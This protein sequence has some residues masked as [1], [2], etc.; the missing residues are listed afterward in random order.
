MENNKIKKS[1][2]KFV[3]ILGIIISIIMFA[4]GTATQKG[5]KV[6]DIYA[7][8]LGVG[9]IIIIVGCCMKS[10]KKLDEMSGINKTISIEKS[11]SSVKLNTINYLCCYKTISIINYRINTIF[12]I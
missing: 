2:K 10:Q 3:I 1:K 8:G 4:I 12:T 5:D 6:D 7:T 11:N 9:V